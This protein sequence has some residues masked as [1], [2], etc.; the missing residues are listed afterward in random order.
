MGKRKSFADKVKKASE[1]DKK[2]KLQY[3]KWV[4]AYKAD[5]GAWKF[6]TVNIAVTEDNKSDIYG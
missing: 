5:N 6:H 4:K 1:K 3:V 2:A